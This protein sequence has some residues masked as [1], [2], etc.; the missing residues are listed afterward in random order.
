MSSGG[1]E[2]VWD[3]RNKVSHFINKNT[4]NM[5]LNFMYQQKI[6]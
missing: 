1:I 4:V 3:T 5:K 6:E 2:Y